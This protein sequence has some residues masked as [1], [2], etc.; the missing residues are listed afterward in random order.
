MPTGRVL[1]A[2]VL[3]FWVLAG[4]LATAFGACAAMG[5]T[6]EGPCGVA[7]CPVQI[8][9]SEWVMP[10]VAMVTPPVTAHPPAASLRVLE[11]PPKSLLAG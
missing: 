9:K 8:H 6:C 5:V 2:V 7:S 10:L 1:A 4:P 11:P 3:V